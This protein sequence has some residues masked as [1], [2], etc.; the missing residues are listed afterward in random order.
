MDQ[1]FNNL[2]ANLCREDFDEAGRR[3]CRLHQKLTGFFQLRG[4]A[5]PTVAADEALDR[6]AG[7][8]AEGNDVPD[9]DAVCLR[10][11]R[12]MMMGGSRHNTP[13]STAFLQF[14][15]QHENESD[16]GI[17]RTGLMKPCFDK[18][19]ETDKE[20]L[21]SYC[22]APHGPG[23]TIYLEHLAAQLNTS[24]TDL[25]IRVMKLR[26]GLDDCFK[27]SSKNH[28]ETLIRREHDAGTPH[29]VS[30]PGTDTRRS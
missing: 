17:D 13:E 26:R 5:D 8:I 2:L 15:E 21:D 10:I 14:L 9:I 12:Y 25:N 28:W 24:L 18:L 11:A 23:R 30:S 7:I 1:H 16:T 27:Q 6:A 19:P 29:R 3:Y 4:V 20:L 22:I